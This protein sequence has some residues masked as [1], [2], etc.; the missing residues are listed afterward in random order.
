MSR[1]QV[2]RITKLCPDIVTK[3][4][5]DL[6]GPY[7]RILCKAPYTE[8]DSLLFP[9]ARQMTTSTHSVDLTTAELRLIEA[10]LET[11]EK[12]LSVQSRSGQDMA[13]AQRLQDLQAVKKT[14]QKQAPRALEQQQSW[15]DVART[16]FG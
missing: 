8:Q 5:A 11:Q 7:W 14:V 4:H 10:A 2:T 3:A 1:R 12:I 6:I 16:W 15:S 13:A 9:E